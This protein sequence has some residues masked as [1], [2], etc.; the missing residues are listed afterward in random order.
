MK[1]NH[2]MTAVIVLYNVTEIIYQCLEN[3]KNIKIIIIDNGDNNP[4]IIKNIKQHKNIIKYF[5]FKKNIGFGRA[6]NFG[7]SFV[8]TDYT[9]LIEPDVLIKEKDIFN[10]LNSFENYPKTAIAV[11]ILINKENQI[12]DYLDN[13]PELHSKTKDLFSKNINEILSRK[14]LE[15]DTSVNFCWAAIMLL[16]NKIIR[17]T[18]LF[19]KKIFIFWEDFFLCRKLKKLKLPIT[20]IFSAKAVHLEGMSTKKNFKSQFIIEKHHV[21]SSYI[22][23]DI[24][25]KDSYLTKKMF[26][27]FFRFV[28]YFLIFNFKSSFKNLARFCAVI[29][30]KYL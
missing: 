6:C 13:L 15:G 8:N 16:N 9:L 12:I 28:T 4:K 1:D 10:L 30:F 21:L 27:F 29:S 23:F 19:N 25:K 7:F 20:K 18:G 14:K 5:K 17:K 3:L 24:N 2:K 26:L 11:P 22:Y